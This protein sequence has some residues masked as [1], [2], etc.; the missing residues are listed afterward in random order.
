MCDSCRDSHESSESSQ[1]QEL[2]T[3]TQLF[4]L[5]TPSGSFHL[6]PSLVPRGRYFRSSA[7]TSLRLLAST[8]AVY[9]RTSRYPAC[10]TRVLQ[11]VLRRGHGTPRP[12]EYG[13]CNALWHE[14]CG[15][16]ETIVQCCCIG[17]HYLYTI[18]NK[19]HLALEGFP[20]AGHAKLLR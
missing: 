19:C 2:H 15:V 7:Q 20:P 9:L 5:I 10:P 11:G 17:L 12:C 14:C 6:K 18:G 4:K 13:L 1:H 16:Q 3:V 8:R